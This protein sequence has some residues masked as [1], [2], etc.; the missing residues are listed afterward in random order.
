VARWR[1]CRTG[2]SVISAGHALDFGRGGPATRARARAVREALAPATLA[3]GDPA[4]GVMATAANFAGLDVLLRAHVTYR[5]ITLD[6]VDAFTKDRTTY[7]PVLGVL[8]FGQGPGDMTAF[9]SIYEI[10]SKLTHMLL[11]VVTGVVTLSDVNR[12]VYVTTRP[13][14]A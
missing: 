12:R 5:A 2:A 11:R 9:A 14:Y 7:L 13:Y 3:G 1:A 6:E 4:A 8:P 10:N